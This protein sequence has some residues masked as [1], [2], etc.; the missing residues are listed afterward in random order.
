[1]DKLRKKYKF[2]YMLLFFEKVKCL[3]YNLILV[4][5]DFEFETYNYGKILF[6]IYFVYVKYIFDY[7]NMNRL[8][9]YCIKD[10]G[11]IDYDYRIVS[12]LRH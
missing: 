11:D 12:D 10:E 8:L 2:C 1:M 6:N 9:T 3:Y 5:N 7:S 4:F